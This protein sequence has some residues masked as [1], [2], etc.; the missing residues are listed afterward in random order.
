MII[1]VASS[2]PLLTQSPS[3]NAADDAAPYLRDLA[4]GIE[5]VRRAGGQ[6]SGTLLLVNTLPK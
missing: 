6:V 3:Q 1:A 5:R 2:A 4:D